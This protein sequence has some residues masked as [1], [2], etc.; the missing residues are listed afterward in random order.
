M[1]PLLVLLACC[2][3]LP[4]T[5]LADGPPGPRTLALADAVAVALESNPD[6]QA[7]RIDVT[8]GEA[9]RRGAAAPTRNPLIS[10]GAGAR[11]TVRPL[12]SLRPARGCGGR[13]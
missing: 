13:S 12:D 1:R 5:A 6:V 4:S 10:I 2:G 3:F 8:A 9:A 11:L 7:A